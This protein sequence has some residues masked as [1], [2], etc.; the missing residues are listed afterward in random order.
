M[1]TIEAADA[2]KYDLMIAILLVAAVMFLFLHS[3]RNSLI[4]MVSIPASLLSTLF[5]MYVLGF[6]LNLMTLLAMSLVIGILVD[7]SIVVLENIYR[8]LEMGKDKRTAALDGRNEIGFAAL[9]ITL[10]DVVVFVPLSFV[11]GLVGNILREFAVVVFSSTLMSL[12]VSFTITPVIA[13]RISKLEHIT[14]S[15]LMGRFSLFFEKILIG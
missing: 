9:S 4:V 12:F 11:G 6:T 14:N 7:D 1:F 2:V 15:T 13:S 8:H 3:I 10:V 5:I